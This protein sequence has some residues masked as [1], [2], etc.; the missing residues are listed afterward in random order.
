MKGT[1][2]LLFIAMSTWLGAQQTTDRFSLEE[3]ISYG[4]K[5]NVEVQNARLDEEIAT[6]RVKE[7]VG[8]GLPQVSGSVT[9]QQSPTQQ[10]FFTQYIPE[11][12]FFLTQEQA[13]DLGVE[14]GDVAALENIF[15]LKGAGDASLSINQLIFNGSYIVGLQASQ[16]YKDLSIKSANQTREEM[17]MNIS[18][19]Y[20]NVLIAQERL[21]LVDANLG[22]LDSLYRNT[23]AMYESGFVEKIDL[24][25]LRVNINNLKVNKQSM[26]N[27][28]NL[29]T[30]LL[31]FQMNYPFE[32][33]LLLT[34]SLESEAL[35]QVEVPDVTEW[36]Y[37]NRPDYQVLQ[38]NYELQKL[39]IRN[40][41]AE[42]LPS[43][44]AFANLGYSTQSPDFGGIFKT[45]ANF[46]G[47]DQIGPDK[48]YGYSTLG[49]RLSWNL[50]TG[51]QRSY[52]IQQEKLSLSKIDN[53][54]KSL[55]KSIEL[56][57]QK[58]RDNLKDALDALDVQS[59][60]VALATNIFEIT[61]VKYQE[62]VGSSLEVIEADTDLKEAQ[63]NY[64]NALYD[65]IIA[66]LELKKALGLLYNEQ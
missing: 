37:S 33:E 7:T 11:S 44:S 34:G 2:T 49:L 15:Q 50:F 41:Y 43:I 38:A 65:A 63:T 47:N 54:F 21:L 62:G 39:N 59:E 35:Q 31:K 60:N 10:R 1:L 27:L 24:D 61:Q 6:A 22:R 32:Q 30:R 55:E 17:V 57:I 40:K 4:L 58:S 19:A 51:L 23:A 5:N 46:S 12:S 16:A 20:Y 14:E 53:G 28:N 52:Q 29:S 25:R 42:A 48:W 18:K 45:E 26:E 13:A 3:C 9:V 66:Q 8:I 64:Y 56:D 36:E